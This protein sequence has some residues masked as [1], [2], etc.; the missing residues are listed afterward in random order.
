MKASPRA[1]KILSKMPKDVISFTEEVSEDLKHRNIQFIVSEHSSVKLG[2]GKC[3]GYFDSFERKLVVCLGGGLQRFFSLLCHEYCHSLQFKNLRSVY[4]DQTI[5]ANHSKFFYW[6]EGAK[7]YKISELAQAA[8]KIELECEKM[9]LK[10]IRRKFSHIVSPESYAQMASVY[11]YGYLWVAE[12][13]EWFKKPLY[14]PEI[15]AACEPR[16]RRKYEVIPQKLRE[17]FEK[18]L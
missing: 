16:L 14:H 13:G 10:L 1:K 3:G 2:C 7:H 18:Y 15:L 9:A 6:L 17:A 8:I 12:T 11:L 5:S 4:N